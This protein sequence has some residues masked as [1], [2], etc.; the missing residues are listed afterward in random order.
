MLLGDSTFIY[1]DF[2]PTQLTFVIVFIDLLAALT[3]GE[4]NHPLLGVLL[5]IR[6][7]N[8]FILRPF[9][10]ICFVLSLLV[11]GWFLA[12][13][14]LLVHV[15]LVQEIFNLKEKHH[16]PKPLNSHYFSRFYNTLNL[17]HSNVSAP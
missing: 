5:H 8:L 4:W 6:I 14:L 11:F 17:N 12:W 2:G 9:V 13:K 3:S 1:L 15:P 10:A 16:L 7:V